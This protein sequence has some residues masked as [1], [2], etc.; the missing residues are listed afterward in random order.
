MPALDEYQTLLHWVH[1]S[2]AVKYG[3]S[4][5]ALCTVPLVFLAINERGQAAVLSERTKGC[6][7]LGIKTASNL[8]NQ[9]D[10]HVSSAAHRKDSSTARRR[11]QSLWIYP[12]KSCKGVELD[13]GTVIATGMEY[14]RQFTF[15]QLKE[16]VSEGQVSQKWEF[17][18]QRQYPLLATVTTEIW[19]PDLTSDT[20]SPDTEQAQS[21][22]IVILSFPRR[23][24]G[25]YGAFVS[26][27]SAALGSN[28]QR[29][30]YLPLNP[31]PSQIQKAG[32]SYE[33][34]RIWKD[35]VT[36]LNMGVHLVPEL[37]LY[38]GMK[39]KLG[40]FRIDDANLRE[41]Y[42]NA[43]RKEEIGYQPITGFQDAY[44][45][46]LIN[47]MSIRDVEDQMPNEKGLPRLSAERFRANIIFAG[48]E[49]YE[50]DTWKR[51][52]I[53]AYEYDVSCRTARCKLPN[54]DQVTG[55]RHSSEP[56]RTLRAFR[57]VDVGAGSNTGC[58]GMQMVP[59]SQ[60]SVVKVGDEISV[61]S[62]G[63]H[64]YI[65]Q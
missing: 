50:E 51:I 62:T 48:P 1:E 9:F 52:E 20:Y 17:I 16:T 43:P 61:L 45:L 2:P 57:S 32:Y 5:A 19:V 7:K 60:R 46:H 14:D 56:D 4:L 59:I 42:R 47:L 6:K 39:N 3:L 30:I 26:W 31:S 33:P 25:W 40:L 54:V 21:N 34:V 63:E 29:R 37:G 38:L 44:P 23:Q 12:V 53:G 65:K 27:I 8:V 36:A 28:L 15:A 58:L 22:G 41:V 64:V 24:P 18:T 13:Q 49:A 35:T 11:V 10:Q 55:E